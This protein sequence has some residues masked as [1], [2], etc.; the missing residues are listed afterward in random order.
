M[1]EET[2]KRIDKLEERIAILEDAGNI[3]KNE[4]QAKTSN[5]KGLAGGLRMLMDNKFFDQ[6]KTMEEIV[7][8]LNREGYYNT[9]AG[10]AS[11]L[12]MTFVRNQKVLN[13]IKQEGKWAYARRR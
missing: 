2:K 3:E 4:E 11:T 13:R 7:K 8:E 9:Y 1:D 12:Y 6:P 10:V 5:Y